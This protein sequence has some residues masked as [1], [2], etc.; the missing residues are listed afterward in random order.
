MNNL[1]IRILLVAVCVATIGCRNSGNSNRRT[2]SEGEKISFRHARLLNVTKRGG[3]IE[4]VVRNPWDT[5]SVLS[6]TRVKIPVSKV[7]AYSSVHASLL[8][9]LGCQ[10]TIKG[11]CDVQ[12][13][14]D[15]VMKDAVSKGEI[16][17]LG[18]SIQPDV[19]HIMA[20][21]ADILLTSPHEGSAIDGKIAS[22][23]I[24]VLACADYME[25]SPLARA[26]WIRL[27]GILVGKEN[28]AD[29]IFDA[30]EKRY[31]ELKMMARKS[32]HRP[33]LLAEQPYQ[34][35]WHVP[36]GGSTSGILY[37]D[38]GADYIFADLDG[39]GSQS[40]GVET[41]LERGMNADLW[42]IKSFGPLS[43]QDIIRDN[44][45]LRPIKAE[46]LVCNTMVN[47]YYGET[48][49]HPDLILENLVAIFH[50][51]LG[52]NPRKTYFA[53]LPTTLPGLRPTE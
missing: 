37:A 48:P 3:E 51:D 39:A 35:V 38:A 42:L 2:V 22:T 15:T 43:R 1:L 27:F 9:E 26:E 17:D 29:S 10:H 6:V 14:T 36:C 49:F 44:P 18:S 19:E 20:S 12:Y 11:L 34:G 46:L 8:T 23:G 53:K 25:I 41:I 28:M 52:I 13:L 21:G 30:V 32:S 16:A 24:P 5:L 7:C 40:V 50:P 31:N 4:I 45:A 47:D 33:T